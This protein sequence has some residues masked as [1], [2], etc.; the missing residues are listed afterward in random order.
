MP[1]ITG[2]IVQRTHSFYW[3]FV[4]VAILVAVG[5]MSYAFVVGR[6]ETIR[7]RS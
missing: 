5:A 3:A 4:L 6:I 2:I 7:W 1:W